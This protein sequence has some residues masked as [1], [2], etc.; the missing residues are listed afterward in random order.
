MF[1][2]LKIAIQTLMSPYNIADKASWRTFLFR[3]ISLVKTRVAET[4]TKIDDAFLKH[5]EFVLRSDALFDYIY[6]V[7]SDQL[8]TEG[9]LFESVE[10]EVIVGLLENGATAES[11]EAIDPVVIISLITQIV[12]FINRIKNR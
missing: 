6:G 3:L 8:Q 1:H 11:P 7:I 4:D 5:I 2:L 12:S 10:E 9:T